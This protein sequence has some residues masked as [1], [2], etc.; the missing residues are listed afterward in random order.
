M[1]LQRC[2]ALHLPWQ[3]L[4]TREPGRQ[5]ALGDELWLAAG[6]PG[7]QGSLGWPLGARWHRHQAGTSFVWPELPGAALKGPPPLPGPQPSQARDKSTAGLLP[8]PP[9]LAWVQRM[10]TRRQPGGG[11]G[12]WGVRPEEQIQPLSLLCGTTKRQPLSSE[13]Q[14]GVAS[15]RHPRWLTSREVLLVG[16]RAAV[17][18]A[19]DRR[20]GRQQR[21]PGPGQGSPAPR[22]PAHTGAICSLRWEQAEPGNRCAAACQAAPEHH[23]CLPHVWAWGQ[24]GRPGRAGQPLERKVEQDHTGSLNTLGHQLT[25][26]SSHTLTGG[27]LPG[28]G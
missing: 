26:H 12:Q 24:L 28:K 21:C 17:E 19:D 3:R 13:L 20:M 23:Q 10:D 11:V 18:G 16:R 5:G 4:R 9:G 6:A 15:D 2:P 22:L 14:A 7:P 8:G 1:T 27:L 25:G